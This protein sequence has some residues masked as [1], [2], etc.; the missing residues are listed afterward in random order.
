[1]SFGRN[2]IRQVSA[3]DHEVASSGEDERDEHEGDEHEENHER[4]EDKLGDRDSGGIPTQK[5]NSNPGSCENP[6][7]LAML[8]RVI[9]W[10]IPWTGWNKHK[11]P[12]GR[13]CTVPSFHDIWR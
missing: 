10:V 2:S 11:M 1:M 8:K 13:S 3:T 7:M 9:P 12:A 5:L 4:D 6:V